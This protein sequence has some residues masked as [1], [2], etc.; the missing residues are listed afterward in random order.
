MYS[1]LRL[2]SHNIWNCDHNAP[3]WEQRGM[4]CSAQARVGG[5]LQV[6]REL[7]PDIIGCQEASALM[8][9]LLKEGFQTENINYTVIWGRFT[10][11]L[12]N[13]AKLELV[14]SAFGTYPETLPEYPGTFNDALSKAWNLGVFRV[15]ESGKLFIFATT[16]LWWKMAP[17]NA[18][19][20]DPRFVQPYSDTARQW[21][22]ASL[23]QVVQR[24]RA[25]YNCPAFVV[26]DMNTGYNTKA[27]QTALSAGFR[28]AHDIATDYADECVGY[29]NCF[30]WILETTY[31]DAPF[32]TSI[33]HILV[34]GEEEG[35]VKR[36]QRYSPEYYIP[37]SDHSP[38]YVD[39]EL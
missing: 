24:Y 37:I 6:Y 32:E 15:K 11:I 22:L 8:T 20:V 27:I 38:V 12:Y 10:P 28:H 36:F 13:A 2:M 31:S 33:D 7:Q 21:Q 14:D 30:P 25:Q 26:G 39:I 17:E 3:Y 29:H 1:Q 9:D 4:D 23:T 34:M 19:G 5:L 16:H 18:E 35:T